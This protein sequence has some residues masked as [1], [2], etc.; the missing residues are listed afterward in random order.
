MT[1]TVPLT[2][3]LKERAKEGVERL[4]LAPVFLIYEIIAVLF[5]GILFII[6]LV[7]KGN[8]GVVSALQSPLVGYK[9]KLFV[10]V[11]LGYLAGKVFSIPT[12]GLRNYFTEQ[13][14][15]EAGQ[16][17]SKQMPGLMKR[18]L[19]GVF[20]LPGLFAS[21]HALDYLVLAVMNV[22]LSVTTGT[23]LLVSSLI[24]GDRSLRWIEAA[25]GTLLFVRGYNGFRACVELA[26][27]MLGV[28][29][30]GT[31]QKLF[32]GNSMAAL[33]AALKL[34]SPQVAAQTNQQA[35]A[36]PQQPPNAPITL[37]QPPPP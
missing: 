26:V 7:V 30:S 19:V 18:F 29:L 28:T 32:P 4:L 37:P 31:I 21:E 11:L 25:I 2:G 3:P 24:P 17:G 36:Q 33:E 16:P 23:V 22:S 8:H 9:T 27:S 12:D 35:P 34:M 15:K 13:F 10:A 20:F 5:P 14:V 6:L 1:E